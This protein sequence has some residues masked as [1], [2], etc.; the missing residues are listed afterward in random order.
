MKSTE[1][2]VEPDHQAIETQEGNA[3]SPME[4]FF[5]RLIRLSWCA[6][7]L[8]ISPASVAWAAVE[9]AREGGARKAVNRLEVTHGPSFDLF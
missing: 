8:T 7:L 4:V 9:M 3:M 6:M 1:E 2:V 5:P